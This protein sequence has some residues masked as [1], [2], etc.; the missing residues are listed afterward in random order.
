MMES[1]M[2]TFD[3]IRG[4]P[5][6]I[7]ERVASIIWDAAQRDKALRDALEDATLD[8]LRWE[9]EQSARMAGWTP[10]QNEREM[11]YC[12]GQDDQLLADIPW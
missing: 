2:V 11:D 6:D 3:A 7:A 5:G 12:Q 9:S 8:F 4:L 10:F 1:V